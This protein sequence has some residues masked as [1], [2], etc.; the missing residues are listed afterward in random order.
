M[1]SFET[2]FELDSTCTNRQRHTRTAE[3]AFPGLRAHGIVNRSI[4]LITFRTPHVGH[5]IQYCDKKPI[6]LA[7]HGD[8][9]SAFTRF[10]YS[11]I[12]AFSC[13]GRCDER[14]V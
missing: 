12:D 5:K 2:R 8:A 3:R 7:H 11:R 1:Q 6:P 9:L 4:L 14:H 10:A 13:C